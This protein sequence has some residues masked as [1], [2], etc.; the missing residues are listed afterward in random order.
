MLNDLRY[1]LRHLVKHPG[2]TTIAVLTLALGIGANTA[3]FS[4]VNAVLFRPL[5]TPGLDRLH[6]IRGDHLGLGLRNTQLAPAEVLDLTQRTDVFEAVTGIDVR[7]RTL[8]GFGDPARISVAQTIGD[9]S[10]VFAPRPTVGAFYRPEQSIE[11]PYHVAVVSHGFWQQQGGGD[12]SFVGGTIELDGIAHEVIGVMPADFGYPRHAQVWVPFAYVG[13]FSG[14]FG[15]GIWGMTAVAR[16][17]AGMTD[18]QLAAHLSS[19]AE[20][21][22]DLYAPG[23]DVTRRLNATG[24]VGYVAGTLQPILLVLMGAVVFVLIIAAAN[25]A[26]LQLVRA[27]ARSKELAVRAAIG[28]GRAHIARQLLVESALLAVGGGTVGLWVGVLSLE[29]LERWPPA[30]LWLVSHIRLDGTVLAFTGLV[31]LA[32]AVA[33][34]VLPALRGARVDPGDVLSATSRGASAGRRFSRLLQANVATQLALALLLLLGSGLMIRTLARLLAADSGFEPAN[35][36]T[37]QISVPGTVYDSAERRLAFFDSVLERL[38]AL[39]GV[40]DV[41]LV[42]GL[43]FSGQNDSSPFAIPNRPAEP[44]DPERHAEGRMVSGGYFEAMGIPLLRGRDFD[45]TERPEGPFVAIV[46]QTFAEQFFPGADPVGQPLLH[47]RGGSTPS[48]IIGV[49]GRVD[50]DEIGDAPKAVVYHSYRQIPF[51]TWRS[52]VIRSDRPV[53]QM[54][55]M[56]RSVVS[57]LDPN[58]PVYDVQTMEGRV[59]RSLGPQR[60]A[61]LA[62]GG[63]AGLSLMLSALG[64]Y[65]VMR[66]TTTQRTREFGIRVAVGADARAVLALVLRQGVTAIAIGLAVG[67]PAAL[68]LTRLMRSILFGVSPHDPIVYVAA[69]VLL[70]AVGLL[71]SW[72]PARRAARIDPMEALR[73]E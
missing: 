30:Q 16:T 43:P 32:T 41:A 18:A 53:G 19:E 58:V 54:A 55:N 20:R 12:T 67:I 40:G 35:V 61:L 14:P 45:D 49:V 24:F 3:V 11:G 17:P 31:A 73:Y 13:R 44:G 63:F 10:G 65:G 2:F 48:T 64:V 29:L 72:L 71:A 25:V 36:V 15:R 26:S 28:A 22:R 68:A 56:I 5:P 23:T 9:F 39:P 7:D 4:V 46:D 6:V 70:T 50:H 37:A 8:T 57:D 47:Y 66:Y 59:E 60:L 21:W 51:Q 33:F 42:W 27:T 52:V 38:R 1:A 69:T 34:G 62:L